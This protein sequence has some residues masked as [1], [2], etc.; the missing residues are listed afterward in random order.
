MFKVSKFNSRT[1]LDLFRDMLFDYLDNQLGITLKRNKQIDLFAKFMGF[2]SQ[3]LARVKFS[4]LPNITTVDRT[5]SQ[6]AVD[7]LCDFSYSF[8]ELCDHLLSFLKESLGSPIT[9]EDVL[10][11]L[12]VD[13]P[14][15]ISNQS[16]ILGEFKNENGS[17]LSLVNAMGSTGAGSLAWFESAAE[18]SRDKLVIWVTKP[19]LVSRDSKLAYECGV[20]KVGVNTKKSDIVPSAQTGFLIVTERLLAELIDCIQSKRTLSKESCVMFYDF[21]PQWRSVNT[22]LSREILQVVLS[23]KVDG[24]LSVECYSNSECLTVLSELSGVSKI[25]Q[26]SIPCRFTSVVYK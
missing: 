21:C 2:S 22:P 6:L 5:E 20:D 24:V 13:S 10:Q 12:K 17:R 23:S 16:R 26:T 14:F 18:I 3:H 11:E 8:A 9:N 1:E 19:M 25:S 4:S 15:L 7:L